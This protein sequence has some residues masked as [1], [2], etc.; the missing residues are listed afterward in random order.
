M[1]R[2]ISKPH[3]L[4][5]DTGFKFTFLETVFDEGLY[6]ADLFKR[7]RFDELVSAMLYAVIQRLS[8]DAQIDHRKFDVKK[9]PLHP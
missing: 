8:E 4:E 6:F 3:K 5:F 7:I 9:D 1:M 2:F